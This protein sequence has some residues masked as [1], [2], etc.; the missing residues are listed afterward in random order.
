[1]TVPERAVRRFVGLVVGGALLLW[2]TTLIAGWSG[3]DASP[4]AVLRG[5]LLVGAVVGAARFPLRLTPK[6]KVHVDTTL[7]F[8]A[9]LTFDPWGAMVVVGVGT[10]VHQLLRRAPVDQAV[11]N[12]AQTV[13]HVGVGSVVFHAL[14]STTIPPRLPGVGNLAAVAGCALAMH[15]LNTWTVA[16]V[17]ALQ[18]RARPLRVRRRGLWLDLPEHLAQVAAGALAVGVAGREPWLVPALVVPIGLICVSMR[19][20]LPLQA[21][22]QAAVEALA[23]WSICGTRPPPGTRRGWRCAPGSS[24]SASGCRRRRSSPWRR[25]PASTTS[26]R[27]AWTRRSSASGRR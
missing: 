10:A 2:A 21:A 5:A 13:L 9:A 26:A 7:L 25:R 17:G 27:S 6:T 1:M 18:V 3:V 22:T 8:V 14:A 24:G 11:F 12:T 15:L 23:A 4:T 20:G 16:T 19:R